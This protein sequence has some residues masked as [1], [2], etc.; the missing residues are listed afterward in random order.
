VSMLQRSNL[1]V[2]RFSMNAASW[3]PWVQGILYFPK[4]EMKL[5]IN[6][7]LK[8]AKDQCGHQGTR[9]TESIAS[10][11]AVELQSLQGCW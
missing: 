7:L 6:E 8:I 5:K 11:A 9:N 1:S 2:T 4:Q 3:S 10:P